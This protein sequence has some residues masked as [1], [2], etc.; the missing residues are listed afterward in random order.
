[1]GDARRLNFG[2]YSG[3][4]Y[5]VTSPAAY[6][7]GRWHQMTATFSGATGLRLY[8]YGGLVGELAAPAA[9]NFIGYWRVGYD[10]VNTWENAPTSY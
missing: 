5:V 9:E 3:S 7:D 2:V 6:N 8:V 4:R 1:M 10:N